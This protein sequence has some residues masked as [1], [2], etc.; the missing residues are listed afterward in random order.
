MA[1]ARA[2]L[3]GR[4]ISLTI[5]ESN[6]MILQRNRFRSAAFRRTAFVFAALHGLFLFCMTP[7]ADAAYDDVTATLT[8]IIVDG[9]TEEMLA[10]RCR[11]TDLYSNDYYPPTGTAFIYIW[12]GG[13][14]YVDGVLVIDLPPGEFRFRIAHGFEYEPIDTQI[15]LGSADTTI[16]LGLERMVDME[17]FGWYGGDCH[18]HINHGGGYYGLVPANALLMGRAEGLR[19]VNCLDNGYFFTG[20]PDP[21]STDECIV[22]MTE[23]YRSGV[24]GHMGLLG[25]EEE[26]L[27]YTS[28]W[29]PTT[30][31]IADSTHTQGGALVVSAH[32]VS[33]EDF[34]EIHEWPGSGIARALPMD[35]IEGKVDAFEVLSYS[36]CHGGIELDY[37]YRFLNCGFSLPG[38]GGSDACINR[39]DSAPLGGYRTYAAVSEKPFTY[40]GWIEGIRSGRTFVTNGPLFTEFGVE[41]YGPGELVDVAGGGQTLNGTL[42]VECVY[43]LSRAEIVMNGDV[44]LTFA[45]EPGTGSLDTSF[46]IFAGESSWLAARVYGPND[47]WLPVGDSLFA[48]TGPVYLSVQGL[49][50]MMQEDILY[51]S[52]WLEDLGLLVEAE[53]SFPDTTKRDLV[54]DRIESARQYYLDLAFPTSDAAGES[55]RPPVVDLRQNVPNPFNAATILECVV[56][57]SLLGGSVEVALK[58]YDVSGRLVRDIYRGPLGSGNHRFA[59]DGRS[60]GGVAVASGIYFMRMEWSGYSS[61]IKMILIR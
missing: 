8:C 50:V 28:F 21:C 10:A 53:G 6:L 14:F 31:E 32:P 57:P 40:D 44:A 2:A 34:D 46:S 56:D 24:Y 59:W 47:W 29:W 12:G 42:D 15:V 20:G 3:P 61:T 30:W 54:L 52:F 16:V 26:V 18:L 51:M 13:F 17:E 35:I 4:I 7:S 37:W 9:V 41:G 36:N 33:S 55:A 27:P 11:I 48:H 45:F 5:E 43:P 38:C 22:Y 60:N 25:L 1:L 39:I 23:E 19:V 58:V 49:P